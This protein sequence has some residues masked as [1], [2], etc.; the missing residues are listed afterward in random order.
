MLGKTSI[1]IDSDLWDKVKKHCK[2][3]EIDTEEFIETA[4][5]HHMVEKD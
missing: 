3:K 4:I 5:I 2:K 1:K